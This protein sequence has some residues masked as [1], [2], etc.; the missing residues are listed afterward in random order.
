MFI[1]I[2]SCFRILFGNQLNKSENKSRIWI[3]GNSRVSSDV[4][5]ETLTGKSN[6]ALTGT[7]NAGLREFFRKSLFTLKFS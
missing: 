5:A 4:E 6:D 1:F 3:V 7:L 2:N